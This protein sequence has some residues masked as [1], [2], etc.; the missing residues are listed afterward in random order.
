M[1]LQSTIKKLDSLI[2][3]AHS[4]GKMGGKLLTGFQ[5]AMRELVQLSEEEKPEPVNIASQ[6][7]HELTTLRF[8]ASITGLT[9]KALAKIA[10]LDD[11][12]LEWYARR[13]NKISTNEEFEGMLAM[14]RHFDLLV[15][16]D[17]ENIRYYKKLL[18]MTTGTNID[19]MKPYL[20]FLRDL[21]PHLT[22][23]FDQVDC[24]ETV[25]E[26]KA[27]NE[28]YTYHLTK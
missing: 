17:L 19:K 5:D 1:E 11:N 13:G 26:W 2:R 23:W 3:W 7:A 20:L 10:T 14:K 15:E 8:A 9:R 16:I 22:K 18:D 21:C 27:N 6:V 24:G 25:D 4:N 28:L 12:F